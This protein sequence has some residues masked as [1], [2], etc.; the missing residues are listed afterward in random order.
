MSDHAPR[1]PSA[2]ARTP[3]TPAHATPPAHRHTPPPTASRATASS[4]RSPRPTAPLSTAPLTGSVPAGEAR[5]APPAMTAGP[6]APAAGPA[7]VVFTP[8]VTGGTGRAVRQPAARFRHRDVFSLA[9]ELYARAPR[10]TARPARTADARAERAGRTG[11]GGWTLLVLLPGAGLSVPW[12]APLGP[13]A[14]RCA[15]PFSVRALRGLHHGQGLADFT[16]RVR[17]LL[18]TRVG[19][20]YV[21]VLAGLDGARPGTLDGARPGRADRAPSRAR[22]R[23]NQA[24]PAVEDTPGDRGAPAHAVAVGTLLLLAR[25]LTVHG[26]PGPAATGLVTACA[27]EALARASVLA[28][29][30]PGA[31]Q[32]AVPV[33]DLAQAWGPGAVPALACGGAAPGP[34]A[35]AAP[36]LTRAPAHT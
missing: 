33:A 5:I 15:H 7:A 20:L 32:L 24:R 16:A 27:V 8:L 29:R 22:G 36:V 6:L 2:P 14:A 30:L 23:E 12:P 25:L 31:D 9:E 19:R 3:F 35:H 17:P 28:G 11:R 1:T 18:L 13:L 26:F 34:P 4:P 10:G 21:V